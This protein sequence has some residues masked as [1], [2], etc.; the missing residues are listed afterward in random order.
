MRVRVAFWSVLTAGLEK[1]GPAL[2]A[3]DDYRAQ[4]FP[5]AQENS[6]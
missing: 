3:Q 5:G 6:P 2:P 4:Q 1:P